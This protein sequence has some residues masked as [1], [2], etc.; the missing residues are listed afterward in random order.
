MIISNYKKEN[1]WI[2]KINLAIIISLL[3]SLV[4]IYSNDL[5]IFIKNSIKFLN[6]FFKPK[7]IWCLILKERL[8]HIIRY[9][10]KYISNY[11]LN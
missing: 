7:I 2:Y 10:I 11:N 3:I 9:I 8:L 5:I 6:P 4:F 1:Y